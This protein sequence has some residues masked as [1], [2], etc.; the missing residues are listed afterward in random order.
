[1]A[2]SSSH[3]DKLAS[4]PLF[5]ALSKDELERV[6]QASDEIDVEAGRELLTEGRVGHEFFLVLDGQAAVMRGTDKIATLSAGDYFGELALLDKGPRSAT[7]VAEK[8]M[9]VLVIGQREFSGL[10]ETVPG[11]AA[12]LLPGLAQR[13][14]EADAKTVTY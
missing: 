10:L 8:D 2:R 5:A 12:K 14:R 11:L 13:L 1:M 4:V 7:V 3:S 9:L 6:D